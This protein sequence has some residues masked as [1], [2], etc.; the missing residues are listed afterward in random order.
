MALLESHFFLM[1]LFSLGVAVFFSFLLK[2]DL[3]SGLRFGLFL[4]AIMVGGALL[5][6]WIMFPFPRPI[7]GS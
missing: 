7:T 1:L 3:R 5:L 6:S 4:F 2:P